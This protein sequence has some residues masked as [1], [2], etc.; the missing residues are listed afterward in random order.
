M[1]TSA[2][3]QGIVVIGNAPVAITLEMLKL[4]LRNEMSDKENKG[5]TVLPR[6]GPAFLNCSGTPKR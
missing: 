1:G 6:V 5:G 3:Q 4:T 2:F